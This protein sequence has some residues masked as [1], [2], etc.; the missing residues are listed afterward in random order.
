[1][2]LVVAAFGAEAVFAGVVAIAIGVAVLAE[3][4]FTAEIVGAT[5]GYILYSALMAGQEAVAEL[6]QIG[7][8]MQAEDIG[9]F[10]RMRFGAWLTGPP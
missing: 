2:Y 6:V 5:V 9:K 3:I 4:D 8:A 1:M 7:R 10:E